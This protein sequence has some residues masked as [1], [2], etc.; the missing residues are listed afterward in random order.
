MPPLRQ[1][2]LVLYLIMI[3]GFVMGFLY[4]SQTDPA[5]D[6]T[7][8]DSR[9]QL[10]SLKGLDTLRVDYSV[11]QSAQFKALQVFGQLPV[12]PTGGGKNDPFQ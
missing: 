8:V 9:W 10:S 12:V 3:L 7:P 1:S 4:N 2:P 5:A 6:I 11:L